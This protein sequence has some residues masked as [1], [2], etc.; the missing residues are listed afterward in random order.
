MNVGGNKKIDMAALRR[1]LEAAGLADVRTLLQSGNAVFRT[2]GTDAAGLAAM[3]ESAIESEF[4]F[5]PRVFIRTV[6]ELEQAVSDD[7][8]GDVATDPSRHFIGFL[9]AA[10]SKDA[11]AAAAGKSTGGDLVQVV[12]SHLY[13]WCPGG[14]GRS[15]MARVDFEKILGSPVTLRNTNTVGKVIE[16]MRS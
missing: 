15:P 11:A 13:M 16:V 12:G 4:A 5:A 6:R 3:I 8:L 7:P 14:I 9:L 2:D 10:P 1:V